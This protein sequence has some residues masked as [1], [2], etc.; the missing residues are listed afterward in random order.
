MKSIMVKIARKEYYNALKHNNRDT[1]A[2][3]DNY[4]NLQKK[5]RENEGMAHGS[6][7]VERA[8]MGAITALFE[9]VDL[10][11]ENIV[12]K[13]GMLESVLNIKPIVYRQR[14]A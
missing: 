9:T 7:D 5:I 14:S 11:D 13:I 12:G 4:I 2:L 3:K 1:G 10:D 6:T 8:R